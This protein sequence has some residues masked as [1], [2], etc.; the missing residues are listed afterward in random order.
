MERRAAGRCGDGKGALRS[1]QRIAKPEGD[2][3]LPPVDSGRSAI[4]AKLK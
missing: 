1:L 2:S 4:D 3:K